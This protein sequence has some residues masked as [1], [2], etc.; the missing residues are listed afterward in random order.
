MKIIWSKDEFSDIFHI[1]EYPAEYV[2]QDQKLV[3]QTM[4]YQSPFA[5]HQLNRIFMESVHIAFIDKTHTEDINYFLRTDS[6]YLQM[7]FELRGDAFY[8]AKEPGGMNCNIPMGH[9][10]LF[11]FPALYGYLAYPTV[12]NGFSVEIEITLN[13]LKRV[14]NGDL[15]S[16]GDF[17]KDIDHERPTMLGGSSFPITAK[18]RAILLD[19]YYCPFIADLKRIY[20]EGKLLEL[21]SLQIDQMN[22]SV[23]ESRNKTRQ[24]DKDQMMEVRE[25]VQQDIEH[26]YSIEE[27]SKLAGINRTKLQKLF[28]EVHG[29]TIYGLLADLRMDKA[30]EL[31]SSDPNIKIAEVARKVGY[32]NANHFSTAYKKKFAALPRSLKKKW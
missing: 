29:T 23:N 11:Y 27:L 7:H 25:W 21:L 4:L 9:H 10:T 26:P 15:S 5:D 24:Q 22:R 32:K 6:P 1:T 18:M 3:E 28:K 12:R 31:L 20:L 2:E 19:M 17:A 14:F 30:I 8:T 13:Y 16:L